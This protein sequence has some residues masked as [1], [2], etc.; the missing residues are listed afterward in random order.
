MQASG[1]TRPVLLLGEPGVGKEL[2]ARRIHFDSP[3]RE[4]PF[5]M[6]DC[7]LYYERELKREIFG[8]HTT[9]EDAKERKGIW[10]PARWM[11]S[12]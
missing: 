8:Y 7:S 3:Q 1:S 9:R 2:I 5:L 11:R 4:H 12:D 10:A 6:I